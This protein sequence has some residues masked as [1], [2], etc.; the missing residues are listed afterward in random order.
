MMVK[1]MMKPL[2]RLFWGVF[3]I[4]CVVIGLIFLGRHLS[5]YQQIKATGFETNALFYTESP[6]A[7]EASFHMQQ[8]YNRLARE[9]HLSPDVLK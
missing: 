5:P 7:M 6:K 4:G 9:P 8:N 3:G 2:V 1:E